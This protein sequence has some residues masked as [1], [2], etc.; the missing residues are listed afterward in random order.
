[1]LLIIITIN[2][3]SHGC[4]ITLSLNRLVSSSIPESVCMEKDLMEE[5]GL[6][7]ESQNLSVLRD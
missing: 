4:L 3:V 1:M 7:N 6:L 5:V 2:I